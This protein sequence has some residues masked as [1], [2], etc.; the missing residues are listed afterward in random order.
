MYDEVNV[1]MWD[2]G[3]V[4]A[5]VTVSRTGK[6]VRLPEVL[7]SIENSADAQFTAECEASRCGYNIVPSR[8]ETENGPTEP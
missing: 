7:G 6:T 5:E 8:S 2:H 3:S 4:F 1:I